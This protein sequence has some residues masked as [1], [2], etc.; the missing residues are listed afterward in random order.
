ME[1]DLTV[2]EDS[3][4]ARLGPFY[5]LVSRIGPAW[6]IK[7]ARRL[8]YILVP[9]AHAGL[10]VKAK[11]LLTPVPMLLYLLCPLMCW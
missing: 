11:A 3:F 7:S 1:S 8:C 10:N 4:S 5:D 6:V 2:M 9:R